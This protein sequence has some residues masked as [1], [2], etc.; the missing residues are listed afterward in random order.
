MIYYFEEESMF[1]EILAQLIKEN[2]SLPRKQPLKFSTPEDGFLG[3]IC[4]E[5]LI[6][7]TSSTASLK[8]VFQNSEQVKS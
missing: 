7:S 8:T 6:S 4:L 3:V 2:M 5:K 1:F